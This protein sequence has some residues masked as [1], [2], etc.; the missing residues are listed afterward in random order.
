MCYVLVCVPRPGIHC[1]NDGDLL[2]YYPPLPSSVTRYMDQAHAAARWALEHN[3]IDF[4]P[5]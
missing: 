5:V 2:P 1:V 4:R 3:L